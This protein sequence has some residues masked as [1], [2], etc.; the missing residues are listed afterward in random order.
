ML[1][2]GHFD[3]AGNFDAENTEIHS[4]LTAARAIR[5]HCTGL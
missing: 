1:A 2:A 5:E 4:V 3:E